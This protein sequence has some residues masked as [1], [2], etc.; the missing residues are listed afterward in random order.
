MVI[1]DNTDYTA[2]CHF[3]SAEKSTNLAEL[4][5]NL[6]SKA[7]LGEILPWELYSEIIRD[8]I[9]IEDWVARGGQKT[10]D[11]LIYFNKSKTI[12]LEYDPNEI[13]NNKYKLPAVVK[14]MADH[15]MNRME[16]TCQTYINLWRFSKILARNHVNFE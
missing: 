7:K 5:S 16:T 13:I 6:T 11:Y 14:K 8:S 1:I 12:L 10:T 15:W 9:R 3:C 4:A 2:S